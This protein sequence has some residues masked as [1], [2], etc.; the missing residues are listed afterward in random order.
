MPIAIPPNSPRAITF[1]AGSAA[2]VLNLLINTLG[3]DLLS[4]I[5]LVAVMVY[6]APFMSMIGFVVMPPAILAVRKLMKRVRSITLTQYG[7]GADIL[8]AMQ[9]TIQGF[10]HHQGV[11]S[12][13]AVMRAQVYGEHRPPSS[14]ASNKLA[15]VSNRSTP[16][17]EALGGIAIGAGVSLRRISRAGAQCRARR[18]RVVH[19][20]VPAR[21]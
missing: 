20:R 6:Q 5:G 10:T 21:L 4:L 12:R 13:G 19:H 11:Q 14:D 7:G 18:V 8:K 1:G 3:R 2:Q 17:M 15:R 9:E 16:L